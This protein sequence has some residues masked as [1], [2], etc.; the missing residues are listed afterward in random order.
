MPSVALPIRGASRLGE[1]RWDV[2]TT[3]AHLIVTDAGALP[4]AERITREWL[5]AVDAAASRF[6]PDSQV[7]RLAATGARGELVSPLLA[8][9]IRVA[10]EAAALTDGDVDPT[11]GNALLRLGYE[12]AGVA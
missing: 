5:E 3:K 10:L 7:R 6:R 9:L 8:E 4:E 11:L 1:A 12:G 2:W